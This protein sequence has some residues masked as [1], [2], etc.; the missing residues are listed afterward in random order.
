MPGYRR[1]Y[2]PNSTVFITCV[3]NQRYP[4]LA[5]E[6]NLQLFM[7]TAKAV[8]RIHPFEIFAYVLLPDHF[9][10]LIHLPE[11]QPDFSR[12]MQSVKWNYSYNYKHLHN[13]RGQL[14]LWQ[15]G[16]YDHIIRDLK[17][18][19]SHL[20]YIHWNPVK[21]NL[22]T[23]PEEWKYSSFKSWVKRGFYPDEKSKRCCPNEIIKYD[24]E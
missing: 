5:D 9:H 12:I 4:Y 21:H 6:E 3:T 18:F 8:Q 17:D 20:E 1:Y 11:E 16:F 13:I 22:A 23:I 19:E 14:T 10:W 7:T 2:I 24:F 15:R